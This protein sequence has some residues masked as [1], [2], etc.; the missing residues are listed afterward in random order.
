ML[1][2]FQI[3]FIVSAGVTSKSSK[4][5]NCGLLATVVSRVFCEAFLV[6]TPTRSDS[7]LVAGRGLGTVTVTASSEPLRGEYDED[8]SKGQLGEGKLVA[9]MAPVTVTASSEPLRGEYDEDVSD[10]QL[11]E[12]ELV[13]S[14]MRAD[15][16][17]DKERKKQHGW[18]LPTNFHSTT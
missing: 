12:G 8:V 2:N 10:G 4:S 1:N 14:M 17:P 9:S 15:I 5:H 16:L 18:G 7:E 6:A 11:G 3:S 13:A